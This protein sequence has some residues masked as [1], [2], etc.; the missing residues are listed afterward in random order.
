MRRIVLHACIAVLALFVLTPGFAAP[1]TADETAPARGHHHHDHD[2]RGDDDHDDDTDTAPVAIEGADLQALI[3]L[4][5]TGPGSRISVDVVVQNAGPGASSGYALVFAPE[6]GTDRSVTAGEACAVRSEGGFTC[7]GGALPAGESQT[8][9]FSFAP[10]GESEAWPPFWFATVTGNEPDPEPGNDRT[11]LELPDS[12]FVRIEPDIKTRVEDANQDGLAT[13]GERIET[14]V[15]L[16]NTS[17]YPWEQVQVSVSGT[18][19]DHRELEQTIAPGEETTVKFAGVVPDLGPDASSGIEAQV[20][21]RAVG[22][23]VD[24]WSGTLMLIGPYATPNPFGPRGDQYLP[25]RP[26]RDGPPA[27]DLEAERAERERIADRQRAARDAR[28][29]TSGTAPDQS[30][31]TTTAPPMTMAP[32]PHALDHDPR[33]RSTDRSTSA[34][35]ATDAAPG[36]LSDAMRDSEI[37]TGDPAPSALDAGWMD[38][39]RANSPLSGFQSVL[40]LQGLIACVIVALYVSIARA[41]ARRDRAADA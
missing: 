41:R 16:V 23:N 21:A 6:L 32:P 3:M 22:A 17:A 39:L 35:G 33:T 24:G 20:S 4:G 28:E 15:H 18:I 13:P 9:R 7:S 8:H 10:A 25:T 38:D 19:W 27:V 14:F 5:W 30:G 11:S 29:S 36:W 26:D 37:A 31:A 1:A 12:T 34:T 40:V 2:D